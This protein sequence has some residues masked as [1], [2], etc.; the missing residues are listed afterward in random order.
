MTD[1]IF[2]LASAPGRAGVAVI[3]L[4]GPLAGPALDA[5]TQRPRP[6]PRAAALRRFHDDSG[7]VIDSGLALWFPAPA[8][9]TGEDCAEL[10]VHGGPAVIEALARALEALD[11]RAAGP[12]EFTRRAFEHGKLDLTEAEGLADLIDAETE[13][14]RAQ[15]LAQMTGALRALYEGWRTQLISI[16]AAL[17][18]E[19]D[20]PDEDD[21][22]DHLSEAATEPLDALI[23]ALA[24]HLD[25]ARRG[26]R[27][28]EG[29]A[30]ALIG[31]PNAGKSSLLNALAR[32]EAAI[33]TDIPGTTRDVVEVRLVLA[34]FPVIL[35]DTAGLRE[36]ADRVEAEGVRRAL[37]R[38]EDAD[39]RLGVSDVS[40]ETSLDALHERLRPGDALILNKT[41]LA[42]APDFASPEGVTAFPLSATTGEGVAALEAWLETAVR[43]RLSAREAPALSRARHRQG[44]TRA[45]DHLTAAR[46][47]L[48]RGPELAALETHLAIRA[49]EGLTGRVDVEDV[50]DAV[51][52]QFCIGK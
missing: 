10:Q 32:R 19:I 28:R 18:G 34:G 26:E 17:E 11:L 6:A 43:Q 21:V 12:G 15:A 47:A 9:F 40:R 50:L 41:D 25:D 30:I 38:A 39:L 45:L 37:A 51:F 44:V 3:R 4:S 52:S 29:F 2:A 1:T 31:A 35:A 27:V 20:F 24:A 5:L 36:A 46:E 33:V 14:Q 48:A 49:L 8:S 23:K 7:A 42:G 16:L 13:G 22:P